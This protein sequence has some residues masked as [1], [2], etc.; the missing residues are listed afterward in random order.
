MTRRVWTVCA[1]FCSLCCS[2]L[3]PR[4]RAG[5]GKMVEAVAGTMNSVDLNYQFRFPP[6]TAEIEQVKQ[7]LQI[8]SQTLCDATDGQLKIGT[9]SLNAGGPNDQ[10]GDFWHHPQDG[11]SGVGGIA[12]KGNLGAKGKYINMMYNDV[13]SPV[14]AHEM[15]H[16][17][18]GVLDS[19][20]EQRRWGGPCGIGRS[21][22]GG[23]QTDR[24]GNLFRKDE[25][26][27]SIMESTPLRRCS[28]KDP[29]NPGL[30]V[31]SGGDCSIDADCTGT[32]TCEPI[33]NSEFSVASNTDIVQGDTM[34][35]ADA[36]AN[37][38]FSPCCGVQQATTN[39]VLRGNLD[40]AT[41]TVASGASAFD[42]TDFDTAAATAAFV[43]E[44]VEILDASSDRAN[45]KFESSSHQLRLY[46]E[47]LDVN[48]WAIHFGLDAQEQTA[49]LPDE[50]PTLTI[51]ATLNVSFDA[52][53]V[54]STSD[55]LTLD[56][57]DLD[58]GSPNLQLALDI[59]PLRQANADF[60]LAARPDGIPMCQR[61][62]AKAADIAECTAHWSTTTQRY[63]STQQTVG[64]G[65]RSDWEQI[66]FAFN[67]FEPPADRP[68]PVE[69]PA[70]ALAAIPIN[71]VP[72]IDG[73]DQ[74]M[75]VVDR[76]GSMSA[77][78]S[79][80]NK[81]T[82]LEFAQAAA[83]AF[84]E[85]RVDSAVEVGL[86]QF[87]HEASVVEGAALVTKGASRDNFVAKIKGLTPAGETAIGDGLLTA[88]DELVRVG[89]RHQ[90]IFLLSDGEQNRGTALDVAKQAV[91]DADIRVFAIAVGA[92]ADKKQLEE[93]AGFTGG[94][95]IDAANPE[96]LPGIYAELDALSRGHGVLLPHLQL[97]LGSDLP[98][99][100]FPLSVEPGAEELTVLISAAEDVE[101][102]HPTVALR[103]PSGV[104]FTSTGAQAVVDPYFIQFRIKNPE[105]GLWSAVLEAGADEDP[106]VLT[107]TVDSPEPECFAALDRTLVRAGETVNIAPTA[108]YV[109]E[110][111]RGVT[112]GGAVIRPNGS[113]IAL[114]FPDPSEGLGQSVTSTSFSSFQG[115]GIY[116]VLTSCI[117]DEA[118]E[119]SAGDDIL[120]GEPNDFEV[121][122]F[123]RAG[124]AS[125]FYDVPELAPCVR[126]FDCDNDGIPNA[127]ELPG[128]TDG[129]GVINER[130]DDADG[131]DLPDAQEG[132]KDGDGDGIPGAYDTD[133]D[134]DG[135]RDGLDP[136]P[137]STPGCTVDNVP[138][139]IVAPA[140]TIPRCEPTSAL[141]TVSATATDA[142]CASG[143]IDL[144]ARLISVHGKTLASPI[145]LSG[146]TFQVE[147]PIGTSVVEWTATDVNGNVRKVQQTL[148]IVV[149]DTPEVCCTS[150]QT[151][152]RGDAFPNV[153]VLPLP[154][155]H[156]IFGLG[157]I[158]TIKTGP[159]PD[160]I[161]GGASIDVITVGGNGSRALGGDGND[162]ITMPLAGGSAYGGP[163]DDLLQMTADGSIH[164]N[165]G[166]D[167][168]VAL[169]GDH[170]I[171]GG[172]GRDLIEA[173]PGKDAVHIYDLCEVAPFEV[174][175]GS[176]GDD[177]LYTPVPLGDL[178]ARG[179]VVLGFEHVVV[180]TSRRHLSECF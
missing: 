149:T 26:N 115:R 80:S 30:F 146:S 179:V 66:A 84:I 28:R 77:P 82:R 90:T 137:T 148:Q 164:G 126:T 34:T 1:L 76:S 41:A 103:S 122:A 121:P 112:Y 88:R 32:D 100:Q 165:A 87:N 133:S 57:T 61:A 12:R 97:Q 44:K 138:P 79:D 152:I 47:H 150:D 14:L 145:V 86:V 160:F 48:Q 142:S 154:G 81:K 162:T 21:F 111:E 52:A 91:K 175:D 78:V 163:G 123:V 180:D 98:E 45:K 113:A 95:V 33:L 105:A 130:D 64:Q 96:D 24:N 120:G 29:A 107:A 156:C 92:A 27:H 85:R 174:I 153:F 94:E 147:L 2:L 7:E 83:R 6:T 65:G 60:S 89:G 17:I 55:P 73:S 108:S 71:F 54:P 5:E 93:V 166:D 25:T 158:D 3:P 144:D 31:A 42:P 118:A 110:I 18:F 56:L 35:C 68:D 128:D 15:T 70:C 134:N 58:T 13:N 49:P 167:H 22:E 75:L 63:E 155:R 40:L 10:D 109:G 4:A 104:F 101:D 39:L 9:V 124:T 74:V 135:I 173:G 132:L 99:L 51:L 11:R 23:Q 16:Y 129:D 53:G 131:D 116:R 72:N 114:S 170:T 19:Y 37:G 119:S 125:F 67:F 136:P 140:R 139:V 169:F 177:T 172:P 171:V 157:S 127:D 106:L 46:A 102:W 69:P 141:T 38:V 43:L 36:A 178:I 151:I 143:G 159:L 8:A 62:S 59:T 20:D 176:L 50:E 168:I 161:S 117:V